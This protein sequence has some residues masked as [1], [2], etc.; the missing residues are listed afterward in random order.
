MRNV[1]TLVLVVLLGCPSPRPPTLA[2]DAAPA[3]PRPATTA[4]P[5][6]VDD[7]A[8][9][10]VEAE[11]AGRLQ[12]GQTGAEEY[13]ES[14]V[15]RLVIKG[16]GFEWQCGQRGERWVIEG[17]QASG[18]RRVLSCGEGRTLV[19]E[20]QGQQRYR[21]TG[22]PCDKG[23]TIYVVFPEARSFRARWLKSATCPTEDMKLAH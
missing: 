1:L 10:L 18:A 7:G 21:V 19:L 2:P 8:L 17:E 12:R 15:P 9:V 5:A 4:A 14:D 23:P 3:A 6:E 13:C 11:L 20:Q 16:G 22:S